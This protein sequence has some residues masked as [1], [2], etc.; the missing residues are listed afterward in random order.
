MSLCK[1]GHNHKNKKC[2]VCHLKMHH[3]IRTGYLITVNGVE[4]L[5]GNV[6]R[7]MER[8]RSKSIYDLKLERVEE[9]DAV[10]IRSYMRGVAA[11]PDLK[12]VKQCTVCEK[13]G[14][15]IEDRFCSYKCYREGARL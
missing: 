10:K 1:L 12:E 13:Y 7:T 11:R 14:V 8:L 4:L 6:E 2:N 15:K 9:G 3:I 5:T